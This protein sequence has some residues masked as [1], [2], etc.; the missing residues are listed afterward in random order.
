MLKA[1][2]LY[3]SLD[4]C[5]LNTSYISCLSSSSW[6]VLTDPRRRR[7]SVCRRSHGLRRLYLPPYIG[8]AI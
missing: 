5:R 1:E 2:T 6:A 4:S 3:V 7:L 8:D